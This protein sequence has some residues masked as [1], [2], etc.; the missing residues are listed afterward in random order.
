MARGHSFAGTEIIDLDPANRRA[1]F[2]A[3]LS[4]SA[5]LPTGIFDCRVIS[6][7]LQA[8]PE[9]ERSL[10][11]CAEGLQPGGRLLVR[12]QHSPHTTPTRRWRL[13]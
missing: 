4:Q 12:F 10:T 7:T 8:I 1:T 13:I 9:A 3:D 2:M 5:S 11:V 6:Q